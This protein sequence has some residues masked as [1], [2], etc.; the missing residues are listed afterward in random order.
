MNLSV[1]RQIAGLLSKGFEQTHFVII[2]SLSLLGGGHL[3]KYEVFPSEKELLFF[4]KIFRF[5]NFWIWIYFVWYCIELAVNKSRN[6]VDDGLP[7]LSGY[8][9]EV[10]LHAEEVAERDFIEVRGG[11]VR[12][13]DAR[14][15]VFLLYHLA[16]ED[17]TVLEAKGISYVNMNTFVSNGQLVHGHRFHS[18]ALLIDIAEVDECG[19]RFVW[20]CVFERPV[21]RCKLLL[22]CPVVAHILRQVLE[23]WGELFGQRRN[24]WLRVVELHRS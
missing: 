9:A 14:I 20:V 13:I 21:A 7:I 1:L 4:E 18:R 22:D 10:A 16:R 11:N 3:F 24:G 17:H 6:L 19:R 23:H 5:V 15:C 8:G 12:T 2:H